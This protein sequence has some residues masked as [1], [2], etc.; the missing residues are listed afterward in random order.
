MPGEQVGQP[1]LL[2]VL[3]AEVV[4]GRRPEAYRGL[5][6]DA[7]PRVRARDLLDRQTQGK[8]V[9]AGAAITLAEWKAEQAELAHL[10]DHVVA[11]LVVNIQVLG[12]GRHHLASEIAT[13]VSNRRLLL[14]KLEV[15]RLQSWHGLPSRRAI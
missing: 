3:R 5:E 2:L 9:R 12:R 14:R 7:D 10:A 11:E 1:L 6:R 15:H 4:D 13:Q 8:E